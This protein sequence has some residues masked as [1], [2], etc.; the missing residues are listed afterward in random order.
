MNIVISATGLEDPGEA[1]VQLRTN[2]W[3]PLKFVSTQTNYMSKQAARS[4]L[5]C[6]Y[7]SPKNPSFWPTSD[8]KTG[9]T[10]PLD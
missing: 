7:F 4:G 8:G 6:Y 5:V 10:F 2:F 1:I 9:T 3:L